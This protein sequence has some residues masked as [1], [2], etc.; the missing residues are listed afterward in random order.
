MPVHED[1][2]A[3]FE[4]AGYEV[5][6]ASDNRGHVRVGV[7][8]ENADP[9]ELKA[10]VTDVVEADAML[11]WSVEQESREGEAGVATVITFRT[12]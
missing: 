2:R 5:T 6:E 3:A 10:V 1:L 7:L 9:E 4:S 12:R 8:E 11:G